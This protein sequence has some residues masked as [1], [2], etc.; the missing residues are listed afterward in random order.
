MTGQGETNLATG[1]IREDITIIGQDQTNPLPLRLSGN[2]ERPSVTLDYQRITSGLATSEEKKKA[3]S[4][5]LKQ[6]WEWLKK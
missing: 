3:V 4:E 2:I 6:Q 1:Q 5:T